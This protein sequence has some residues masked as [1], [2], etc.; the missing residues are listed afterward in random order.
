MY[1]IEKICELIYWI[2]FSMDSEIN[3]RKFLESDQS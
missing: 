3:S 1:A 2:W